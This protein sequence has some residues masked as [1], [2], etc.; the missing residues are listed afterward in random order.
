MLLELFFVKQNNVG[1]ETKVLNIFLLNIYALLFNI[2][3][4]N[5]IER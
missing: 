1:V 5:H 4:N 3:V 2:Q